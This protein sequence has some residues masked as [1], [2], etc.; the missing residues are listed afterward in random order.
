[1][2][3]NYNVGAIPSTAYPTARSQYTTAV[4]AAVS[5]RNPYEPTTIN[6]GITPLYSNMLG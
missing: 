2:S 3:E 1:M 6:D 5:A 4:S